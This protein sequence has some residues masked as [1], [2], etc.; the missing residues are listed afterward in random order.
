MS[1]ENLHK[2]NFTKEFVAIWEGQSKPIS[3][4]DTMRVIDDIRKQQ[5]PKKD[6]NVEID[7]MIIEEI[8]KNNANSFN[9]YAKE[10]SKKEEKL[11]SMNQLLEVPKIDNCF[12]SPFEDVYSVYNTYKTQGSDNDTLISKLNNSRS[13]RS[14]KSVKSNSNSNRSEDKISLC[15]V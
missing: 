10:N 3:T 8:K 7:N 11:V 12:N 4:F 6:E 9:R 2:D 1:K 14:I 15:K 13:I 5:N